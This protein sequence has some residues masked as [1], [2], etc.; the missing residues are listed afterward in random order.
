MKPEELKDWL[1]RA[2][3]DA[4]RNNLANLATT[5]ET[6]LECID[7]VIEDR[8]RSNDKICKLTLERNQLRT[9]LE[10]NEQESDNEA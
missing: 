6:M 4:R 2:R 10:K 8:V 7:S 5:W 1:E 9:S 3:D